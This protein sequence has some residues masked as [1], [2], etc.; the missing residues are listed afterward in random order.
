MKNLKQTFAVSTLML[1]CVG[2]ATTTPY[3]PFVKSEDEIKSSISVL[4]MKPIRLAEFSRKD[5]VAARYEMLITE[6]LESAGFTVIPSNEFSAIWDPMVEQVGGL[7]D[8]VTGESD[9]DKV[10]AV[11]EHTLNELRAKF[12]VNGFVAPR[13]DVAK[14]SWYGNSATWDGVKDET[15]GKGGFWASLAAANYQGSVPALSLIV[16]IFDINGDPVYVGRGGIQLF[17]HFKGGRFIDVPESMWFVEPERD[18]NAANIA[19]RDLVA[20]PVAT[21]VSKTQ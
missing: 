5:E 16:P 12:S 1:F 10:K 15:T 21:Q 17:A 7:F 6:Q 19:M 11:H 14:A 2:C 13:I 8:P 9:P 18:L 3:D 4:A 20:D